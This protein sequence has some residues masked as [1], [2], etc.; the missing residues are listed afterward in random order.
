[1]ASKADA[2]ADKVIQ[3]NLGASDKAGS[4]RPN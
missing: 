1:M 3:A 2:E 4:D